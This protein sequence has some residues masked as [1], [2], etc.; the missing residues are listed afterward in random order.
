MRQVIT[1]DAEVGAIG[2][3][4]G[5]ERDRA[6]VAG[7]RIRSYDDAVAVARSFVQNRP[8]RL[9]AWILV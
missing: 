4:Q 6:A 9:R 5:A 1:C 8:N 2:R 7:L 3:R